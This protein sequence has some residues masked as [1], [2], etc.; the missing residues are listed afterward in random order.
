MGASIVGHEEEHNNVE[1]RFFKFV[2]LIVCHSLLVVFVCFV[3]CLWWDLY[4]LIFCV[5]G[6]VVG[7]VWALEMALL[8]CFACP[9]KLSM[10]L[11]DVS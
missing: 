8:Y 6:F 3:V 2:V 10:R 5:G 1:G 9:K 7:C 11:E 4:V